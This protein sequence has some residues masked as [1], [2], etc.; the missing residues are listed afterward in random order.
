MLYYYMVLVNS[1]QGVYAGRAGY[2]KISDKVEKIN[3]KFVN[4]AKKDDPEMIT[5][6]FLPIA[7]APVVEALIPI[8]APMVIDAISKKIKGGAKNEIGS[9]EYRFLDRPNKMEMPSSEFSGG[10]MCDDSENEVKI[11]VGGKKK[12]NKKV[13]RKNPKLQR[14]AEL[15]K[16]IM[17]EQGLSLIE[18][19]KYIKKNKMQ[20]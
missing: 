9:K 19:S 20:Y 3:K 2:K 4:K 15:V 8:V 12:A 13:K 17:K 16:K 1:P 5:G 10:C 6:G 11:I 18:A 14:R 7:I